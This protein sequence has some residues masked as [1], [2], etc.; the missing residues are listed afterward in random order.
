MPV[1][2]IGG[3]GAD[4]GGSRVRRS[5]DRAA[6]GRRLQPGARA[7][8]ATRLTTGTAVDASVVAVSRRAA[9]GRGCQPGRLGR[10]PD[11]PGGGST[12]TSFAST[13]S[14]GGTGF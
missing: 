6:S 10:A 13:F 14:C 5:A 2:P 7:P 3:A 1:L 8:S 12:D 11:W 9:T 4:L